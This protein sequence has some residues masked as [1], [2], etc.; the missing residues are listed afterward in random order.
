[1][2]VIIV[3]VSYHRVHR[4]HQDYEGWEVREAADRCPE[5]LLAAQLSGL[6]AADD[7]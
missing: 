4:V 7:R 5:P 3:I 2:I 6:E 1:M